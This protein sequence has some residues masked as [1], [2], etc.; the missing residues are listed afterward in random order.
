MEKKVFVFMNILL[1]ECNEFMMKVL[2]NLSGKVVVVVGF[3]Y[4]DGIE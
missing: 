1:R 3:V 2:R 4:L